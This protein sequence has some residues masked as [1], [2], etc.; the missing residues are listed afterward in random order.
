MLLRNNS[1][2]GEAIDEIKEKTGIDNY[3]VEMKMLWNEQLGDGFKEWV[4]LQKEGKGSLKHPSLPYLSMR[5]PFPNAKAK[6]FKVLAFS[7]LGIITENGEK[8]VSKSKIYL[9]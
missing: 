5:K 6:L 7:E 8:C 4:N 9:F 2:L 3:N 1:F